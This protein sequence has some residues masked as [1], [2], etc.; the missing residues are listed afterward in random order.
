MFNGSSTQSSRLLFK[1]RSFYIKKPVEQNP[2][3]FVLN[4]FIAVFLIIV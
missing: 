3:G 4:P 1:T 2:T